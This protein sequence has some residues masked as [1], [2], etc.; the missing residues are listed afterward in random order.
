METQAALGAGYAA[1]SLPADTTPFLGRRAEIKEVKALLSDARV[2][3]LT[4]PGGVGKS[5][6]ALRV[7][8]ELRRSFQGNVWF[9]ELADLRDGSLLGTTIASALDL[10]IQSSRPGVEAICDHLHD[11]P[12]LLVLD[13]C[14]H[15]TTECAMFVHHLIRS[16]P[17]VVVLATSRQSLAV[18]GETVYP[19]APMRVPLD[20]IESPASITHY[21]S[22]RLFAERAA[23]VSP[24]FTID[25]HNFVTV[26]RI[27][28]K[29]EGIPLAIELAAVRLR[30]LSLQQI[31]QRLRTRYQLLGGQVR[32]AP[33]RQ[34]TLQALIDWS[35]DLCTTAERIVWAR[36]S[37]FSGSFHLEAVEYVASAGTD[38]E[39]GDILDVVDALVDKSILI[40]EQYRDT[41][42]YRMLETLREY[43]RGRLDQRSE[44]TMIRRRHR[45]WYADLAN[46]F[47]AQW[48][49]PD[50][51]SWIQRMLLEHSNIRVALQFCATEFDEARIGLRMATQLEDFWGVRGLQT[52][53]RHWL[54]KT[55]PASPQPSPE[56]AAALRMNGWFAVLQ[57]DIDT[58]MPQL[59]EA[60]ILA[61]ELDLDVERGNLQQAAGLAA[62]FSGDVP[63]AVAQH[64]EALSHFLGTSLRGELFCKFTLGL[65]QG[66]A[67]GTEP[68]LATLRDC[69]AQAESYGDKDWRAWALW[70][71]AFVKVIND[72][73]GDPIRPAK[74]ALTMQ[75]EIDNRLAMTFT[76]DTLAWIAQRRGNAERAALL[77]GAADNLWHGIDSSPSNYVPLDEL[78]RKY[79][80][81]ARDALGSSAFESEFQRGKTLSTADAI[82]RALET[83][84][85]TSTAGAAD[86]APTLLTRREQQIAELVAQGMTNRDIAASLVIS[87]RTAEAHVEHIL[88]KLGFG[89][90]TQ[91]ASW[92]TNQQPPTGD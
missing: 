9:V 54:D 62:L 23:A 66:V 28:R 53:V 18:A 25:E 60:S 57:G 45:D 31:Q 12:A 36:A 19:V 20:E 42:R 90:R 65:G 59:R 3:T 82:D 88:T 33:E 35:Y 41:V 85:A 34:R 15:L 47:V 92:V 17:G 71:M 24:G 10:H 68:A 56:R 40:R 76:M 75:R 70:S 51:V 39:Q 1:A 63:K 8:A 5:R 55:L 16:C 29:L 38:I 84:P 50:Q 21:D 48:I 7:A 11:T 72:S 6:L 81:L 83:R 27:C 79:F 44:T 77:F 32:G 86:T 64:H 30:S 73:P 2:V 52:E 61:D 89:S 4:G 13:N 22:V 91:I 67:E 37:V 69:V 14:E 46:S 43:G 58:A 26:A 78:H 80:G 49:G 74:Q 87:Q